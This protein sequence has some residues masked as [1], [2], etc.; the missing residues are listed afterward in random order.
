MHAG[1][2]QGREGQPAAKALMPPHA[3]A[4]GTRRDLVRGERMLR[5]TLRRVGLVAIGVA[6]AFVMLEIGLQIGALAF[7]ITGRPM[8]RAFLG[9]R[10]RILCLGDSNTYGLRMVNRDDANPQ[11][12]EHLWNA[13][14][15]RSPIEVLNLGY[16]GTNSSKLIHD[17]PR[18]LDTLRPDTVIMMIGANDY[19]TVSI[20]ADAAAGVGSQ[21]VQLLGRYSRVYQFV[22]M[23]GRSFDQRQLEV[24]YPALVKGGSSGTA[25]YGDV[26]F[27]L[28]WKPLVHNRG[29]DTYVE[30]ETNLRTLTDIVRSHGAEPVFLTYASTMWNYGDAST[31]MRKAAEANGVRLVDAA[32]PVAAVCPAEPCPDWLYSDHHPTA[33]GYRLVAEAVMHS[34]DGAPAEASNSVGPI[35]TSTPG[36]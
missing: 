17:L 16:P 18:M 15:D 22:H 36:V 9:G 19:W 27:A 25:R 35:R 26:E 3:R 32:P 4:G 20:P 24:D 7:W 33:A 11:Q 23:L 13:S 34:L 10:R 12:L 5:T 31:A 14:S 30:L 8:A 29:A 1:G 2:D 6:L 28:G 21:V